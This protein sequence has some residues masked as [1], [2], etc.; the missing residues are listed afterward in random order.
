[1][2]IPAV[3][4]RTGSRSEIWRL[5]SSEQAASFTFSAQSVPFYTPLE[6]P[7]AVWLFPPLTTQPKSSMPNFQN[8]SAINPPKSVFNTLVWPREHVTLDQE[9]H[10]GKPPTPGPECLPGWG[11]RLVVAAC[12]YGRNGTH[13]SATRGY[14]SATISAVRMAAESKD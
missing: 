14:A 5:A 6:A 8:P 4:W 7:S 2:C 11:V 3:F 1:M 10:R 12:I 13:Y 9:V